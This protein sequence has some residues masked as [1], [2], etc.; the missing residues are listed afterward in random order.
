MRKLIYFTVALCGAIGWGADWLTDGGS[1]QRTGWQ[2]DESIL[3]KDNVKGLQVLWKLK[4]DNQPRHMHSLFPPLIA[5]DMKTKDGVRQIAI[6][7][8][9]SDNIFAIDVESG[10]VIWQKHFEYPPVTEGRG[11][12][13][14]DPLCP[15]GL[16]ATPVVGERNES[17]DRTLY[18]LAG[19]GK[20]HF[21]NVSDGEDVQP[22]VKF[23]FGDG[24]SKIPK[25]FDTM[26]S[27]E[28]EEMFYGKP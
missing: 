25:D 4:L 14:D 11:Y 2:K 17:G 24:K 21:L 23:G 9:S 16:T 1:P 3:T 22:P 18:A 28:I 12:G 26:F 7:A 8:G 10:K 20:L 6:E 5:G 13:P 27:K 19:D 15:G